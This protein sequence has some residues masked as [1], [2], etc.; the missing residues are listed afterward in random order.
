MQLNSIS[1]ILLLYYYGITR[2]EY[3][4]PCLD[5]DMEWP[6]YWKTSLVVVQFRRTEMV[7][8]TK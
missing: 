6:T 1:T 8:L 2:L 5:T 3:S 7:Q 4:I